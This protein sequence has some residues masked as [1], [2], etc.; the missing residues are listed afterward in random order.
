MGLIYVYHGSIKTFSIVIALVVS[1]LAFGMERGF[2]R[3][4]D[5]ENIVY[6]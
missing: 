1:G 2:E 3:V 6:F 4:G 5:G